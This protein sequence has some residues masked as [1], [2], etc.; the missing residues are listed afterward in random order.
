M[1]PNHRPCLRGNRTESFGFM[2]LAINGITNKQKLIQ[3][4]KIFLESHS[5]ILFIYEMNTLV[6]P[7]T[8]FCIFPSY[9]FEVSFTAHGKGLCTIIRNDL[10]I[11]QKSG[12]ND[13]NKFEISPPEISIQVKNISVDNILI[14]SCEVKI[15]CNE[16]YESETSKKKS[17]KSTRLYSF[18]LA[19]CYQPQ[20]YNLSLNAVNRLIKHD[21]V[22]GDLNYRELDSG[23]FGMKSSV[24][25]YDNY[26]IINLNKNFSFPLN[27][28]EVLLLVQSS[29]MSSMQQSSSMTQQSSSQ[30]AASYQHQQVQQQR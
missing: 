27:R 7:N 9:Q 30:F 14:H 23:G 26:N 10:V 16:L 18:S 22:I 20:F 11:C 19:A 28:E 4:K 13:N 15:I 29:S 6:L 21:M 5:K 25:S 8:F 12:Q 2:C 1:H 17:E 3:L 24:D